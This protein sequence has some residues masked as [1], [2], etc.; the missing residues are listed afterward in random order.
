MIVVI[1]VQILS[2]AVGKFEP[3]LTF[4]DIIKAIISFSIGT[5]HF[6]YRLRPGGSSFGKGE[7]NHVRGP[8]LVGLRDALGLGGDVWHYAVTTRFLWS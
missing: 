3:G 2:T 7:D 4:G 8:E 1:T 6:A 5:E